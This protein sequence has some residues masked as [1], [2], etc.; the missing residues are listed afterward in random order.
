MDINDD[1][2]NMIKIADVNP[3]A[4]QENH[5]TLYDSTETDSTRGAL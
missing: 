1:F 3:N 4:L 2:V 5:T